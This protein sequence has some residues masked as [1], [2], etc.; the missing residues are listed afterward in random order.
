MVGLPMTDAAKIARG[1]TKA[2]REVLHFANNSPIRGWVCRPGRSVAGLE[3]KGLIGRFY[4]TSMGG[5]RTGYRQLTPLGLAVRAEL[6][7]MQ[8]D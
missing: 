4:L 7:R 1:L 3:N 8:N 2:Q 5:S 6:E